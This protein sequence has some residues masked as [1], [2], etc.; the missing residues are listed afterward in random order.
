MILEISYDGTILESYPA[1]L[2]NVT[3][4]VMKEQ[5][6]SIISFYQKLI[7]QIYEEDEG[8]NGDISEI[9][10]DLTKVENLSDVQK[11]ALAYVIA[12][13]YSIET[14]LTTREELEEEGAI[15]NYF[16]EDGILIELST[17]AMK[18]YKFEFKISKWRS[19]L[20]AIGYDN[21]KA[22]KED[23]LWRYELGGAWIS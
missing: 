19:G 15:I 22:Y 21:C 10:L 5:R 17:S 16:Y 18:E 7:H 8:L 9:A 2:S 11:K 3:K 4:V 20:G 14:R 23:N 12:S 6:E 13:D 1:R